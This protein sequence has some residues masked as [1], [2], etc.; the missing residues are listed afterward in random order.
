MNTAMVLN[1]C[2]SPLGETSIARALNL[3][4]TGRAEIVRDR[5]E[6]RS[7]SL[8]VR[9]PD[10][11]RLFAYVTFRQSHVPLTKRA[12]IARDAGMCQ[13][14]GTTSGRMTVDHVVPRSRGGADSWANWVC[15]CFSCNQAKDDRT[16]AEAGFRLRRS[17][18]EPGLMLLLRVSAR[19]RNWMDLMANGTYSI[20]DEVA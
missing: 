18:K 16:P 3:V 5:G 1:A 10:I 8:V 7:A 17:P 9:I 20:G 12:V 2:Y 11:I 14:C 4:R 6:L 19:G 15:A 13:Y